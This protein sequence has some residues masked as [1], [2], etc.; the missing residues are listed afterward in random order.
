M[1]VVAVGVVGDMG[2]MFEKRE[3]LERMVTCN[4]TKKMVWKF[5]KD[6]S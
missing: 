6:H 3:L 4:E 5:L 2:E 1:W